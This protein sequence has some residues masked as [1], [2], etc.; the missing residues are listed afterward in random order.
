[1][2]NSAYIRCKLPFFLGLIG[3]GIGFNAVGGLP[4]LNEWM[5]IL[6]VSL[7]LITVPSTCLILEKPRFLGLL[8]DVTGCIALAI[9]FSYAW[10]CGNF[11]GVHA[12]GMTILTSVSYIIT[13]R[14]AYTLCN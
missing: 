13:N 11:T 7:A 3:V 1:M 12:F 10:Y 4:L 6:S 9:T 2:L 5:L 8:F 14:A